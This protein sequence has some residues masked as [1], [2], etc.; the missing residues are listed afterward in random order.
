MGSSRFFERITLT[1]VSGNPAF[2]RLQLLTG[3]RTLEMLAN[4]NVIVFGIG[5]VGSWCAEALIR[6]GIGKLTIVD[7]DVICVTNINRQIQATMDSIGKPKTSELGKRLRSI[8]PHAEIIEIQAVF[9]KTT[10]QS[11]NLSA[12]DYVI[13]CIDSLSSKVELIIRATQAGATLYSALG[14]SC[15]LD[16]LR[17]TV[18][19]LWE[20]YNCPLGKFVRK[21]L[22]QRGFTEE[23]TC[24]YS[25]EE[26]APPAGTVTCGSGACHCPKFI[27]RGQGN[28]ADSTEWCSTKKQINGSAVHITGIFGFMLAGLV[29]QDIVKRAQGLSNE[30]SK[31]ITGPAAKV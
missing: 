14:A 23:V 25:P 18:G 7:S 10:A 30:N 29:V 27:T 26:A 24:V 16:P 31:I 13:D 5:G 3:E 6:S 15:K 28:D 9:N 20:S 12:F 19:S 1:Y 2:Q 21:K 22:R 4:T 17:I 11:F 8:Q